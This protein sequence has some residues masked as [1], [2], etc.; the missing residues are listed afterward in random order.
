MGGH[1]LK[2]PGAHV[3]SCPCSSRTLCGSH[4]LGNGFCFGGWGLVLLT[5]EGTESLRIPRLSHQASSQG[6]PW[7]G[8]P[9]MG[10]GS[11]MNKG[12][13][14]DSSFLFLAAPK[15][16]PPLPLPAAP[17]GEERG[18]LPACS[19]HCLWGPTSL[20][21]WPWDLSQVTPTPTRCWF[22]KTLLLSPGGT[23]LSWPAARLCKPLRALQEWSWRLW[24]G[25][26]FLSERR[27]GTF[28][29]PTDI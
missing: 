2:L 29:D 9:R 18:K 5:K 8:G 23:G 26:Q 6:Q 1:P 10:T 4:G 24:L 14:S 3:L 11:F 21:T 22:P 15:I 12:L 19:N 17:G 28:P 7:D 13:E 16:Q 27:Q 25:S 20:W